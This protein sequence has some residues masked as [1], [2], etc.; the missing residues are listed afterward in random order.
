M[1]LVQFCNYITRIQFTVNKTLFSF[2]VLSQ[3]SVSVKYHKSY[4]ISTVQTG[5]LLS[6]VVVSYNFLLICFMH[7]IICVATGIDIIGSV[8]YIYI[9]YTR[10]YN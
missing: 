2:K 8:L 3:D 5:R 9:F 1:H 10:S 7:Y 4:N 6:V